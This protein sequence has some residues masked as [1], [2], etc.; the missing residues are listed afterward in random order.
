MRVVGA[1]YVLNGVGL[2]V[3][4]LVPAIGEASVRQRVPGA[5]P[6]NPLYGFAM[7]TWVMFALEVLG[8][9]AALLVAS[10]AAWENRILAFTIVGL[11]LIRGVLDDLVWIANGYPAALYLGWIGFHTVVIV[12]GVRALRGAN[13]ERPSEALVAS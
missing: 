2:V 12:T 4:Y 10:G 6:A 5:D 3:S 8:V 1:L 7:E 13:A 9:G 11:E